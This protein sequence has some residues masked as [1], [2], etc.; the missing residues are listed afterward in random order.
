MDGE[1][2]AGWFLTKQALTVS[3]LKAP[4]PP[5]HMPRPPRSVPPA[6]WLSAG[7]AYRAV[8]H[9]LWVVRVVRETWL[10]PKDD[11]DH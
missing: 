3:A 4:P 8:A 6:P 11:G 9:T 2:W 5:G 7:N 1:G 10:S